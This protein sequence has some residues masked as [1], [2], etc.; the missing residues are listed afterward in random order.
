M[1]CYFE[2]PTYCDVNP[3]PPGF[4]AHPQGMY[5]CCSQG[6]CWNSYGPDDCEPQ[7]IFWCQNG[8]TNDDGTAT[9]FDDD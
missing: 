1:S 8:A 6:I 3:C 5:M 9:C 4:G 2:V 7:D